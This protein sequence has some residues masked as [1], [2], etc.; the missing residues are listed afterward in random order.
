[1]TA[2]DSY[3]VLAEIT[4]NSLSCSSDFGVGLVVGWKGHTGSEQPRVGHPFPGL[5]WYAKFQAPGSFFNIYAN[6]AIHIEEVLVRDTTGRTLALGVKYMFRFRTQRLSASASRYSLKV[7][8]AGTSEP[9]VFDLTVDA[10]AT[11][12][13]LVL[14]AHRADVSFGRIVVTGL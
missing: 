9:P 8:Q 5:G 7:W 6:T 4:T 13:S 3:E 1:M 2:W 12:G 10:E 11:L 14:G